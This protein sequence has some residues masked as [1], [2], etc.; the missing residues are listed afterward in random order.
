MTS[1]MLEGTSAEDALSSDTEE[2]YESSSSKSP[3]AGVMIRSPSDDGKPRCELPLALTVASVSVDFD[4]LRSMMLSSSV[5]TTSGGPDP[6]ARL[7]GIGGSG[8]SV[9]ILTL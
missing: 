9:R 4:S 5:E 8:P 1:S 2:G 3:L 7:S 6:A